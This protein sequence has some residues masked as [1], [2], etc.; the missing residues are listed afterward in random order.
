MHLEER[1]VN[2]ARALNGAAVTEC[3]SYT[4]RCPP[5]HVLRDDMKSLWLSQEGLPQSIVIDLSQLHV[6]PRN[7]YWFGWT[8]WHAYSSNPAVVEL[9][10]SEDG[11]HYKKLAQLHGKFVEG[12]QYF[13]IEPLRSENLYL[14]VVIRETFG[15]S[16]TYINQ[17]LLLDEG[18][19][20]RK[21]LENVGP[22]EDISFRAKLQFQLSDLEKTVQS[23]QVVEE[24]LVKDSP[25]KQLQDEV[26]SWSSTFNALQS[27][28][29]TLLSNVSSLETKALKENTTNHLVQL[30][31]EILKEISLNKKTRKY[32][33]ECYP[34]GSFTS[35][36]NLMQNTAQVP[37]ILDQ[38][39]S[40]LEEK[41]RKLRELQDERT[42]FSL[43]DMDYY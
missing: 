20:E 23:L 31:R 41:A 19:R 39:Q 27:N 21:V 35:E 3:S 32:T 8:C 16:K 25:L 29:D 12:A 37:E 18:P 17:L 36:W 40:K 43:R 24:P 9:Y 6:R 33:P 2:F 26:S 14:K 42:R 5:H 1:V 7:Y 34:Q 15:A 30:K 10:A 11:E 4:F 38:L 28:I 22:A 13:P